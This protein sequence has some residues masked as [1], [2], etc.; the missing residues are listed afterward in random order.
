MRYQAAPRPD[1]LTCGEPRDRANSTL[2]HAPGAARIGPGAGQSAY[3]Q[4][5]EHVVG[6][7]GRRAGPGQR[8]AGAQ[9]PAEG[10]ARTAPAV[11]RAG[12]A[13][14]ARGGG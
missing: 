10:R 14:A 3:G 4:H 11:R 12:G 6:P 13:P 9:R 7:D 2:P 8:G 1:A 5:G